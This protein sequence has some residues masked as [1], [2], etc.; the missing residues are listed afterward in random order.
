MGPLPTDA[1]INAAKLK[2]NQQL[3]EVHIKTSVSSCQ[4]LDILQRLLH[5]RKR[6]GKKTAL[7]FTT[8]K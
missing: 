6:K 4:S 1:V 8:L 5:D 3:S 2:L 7:V